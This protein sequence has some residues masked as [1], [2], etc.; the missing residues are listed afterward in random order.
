MYMFL[1]GRIWFGWIG[2]VAQVLCL[3]GAIQA[4][5]QWLVTEMDGREVQASIKYKVSARNV[6][7]TSIRHLRL[8]CSTIFAHFTFT[9]KHIIKQGPFPGCYFHREKNCASSNIPYLFGQ[10]TVSYGQ[11][12]SLMFFPYRMKHDILNCV[13]MAPANIAQHGHIMQITNCLSFMVC[14]HITVFCL[15]LEQP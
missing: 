3:L 10:P 14:T 1:F 2:Q 6:L 5:G 8:Y 12:D 7:F 15:K 4:S 9:T 11:S 13:R